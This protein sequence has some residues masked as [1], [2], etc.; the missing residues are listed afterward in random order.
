MTDK[1]KA[2]AAG[3][4][5]RDTNK[6]VGPNVVKIYVEKLIDNDY[7][8]IVEVLRIPT[9]DK[10]ITFRHNGKQYL[11]SY[12]LYDARKAEYDRQQVLAASA[13]K[14]RNMVAVQKHKEAQARLAAKP[15]SELERVAIMPITELDALKLFG[16]TK[17]TDYASIKGQ[18]R[19]LLVKY[20]PDRYGDK[21]N[22]ITININKAYKMLKKRLDKWREVWYIIRIVNGDSARGRMLILWRLKNKQVINIDY[23]WYKRGCKHFL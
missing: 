7:A 16:L 6:L 13:Q 8:I 9:G 17:I 22:K 10:F 23:G 4:W 1:D 20:H 3:K 15:L 2:K 18:W 14:Y 21:G 12:R 5:Y 19:E 11:L